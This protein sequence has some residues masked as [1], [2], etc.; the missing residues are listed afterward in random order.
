[1]T[2]FNHLYFNVVEHFQEKLVLVSLFFSP[3][4]LLKLIRQKK[5]KKNILLRNNQKEQRRSRGGKALTLETP[6]ISVI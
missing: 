3:L 6:N 2:L 5:K 1:M 4:S